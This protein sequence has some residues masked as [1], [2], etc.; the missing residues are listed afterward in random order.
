MILV[1]NKVDLLPRD[2]TNYLQHLKKCL[3]ST[4]RE[5]GLGS[6][7]L[8]HTAVISATTGFGVESLVDKIFSEWGFKGKCSAMR[9][10]KLV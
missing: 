10:F 1:G 5:A 8:V 4:A 7:K 6:A 2:T 3:E 9:D